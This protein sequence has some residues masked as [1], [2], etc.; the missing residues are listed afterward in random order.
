MSTDHIFPEPGDIDLKEVRYG[1]TLWVKLNVGRCTDDEII[2]LPESYDWCLSIPLARKIP[3]TLNI[4][5]TIKGQLIK[6]NQ[7]RCPMAKGDMVRTWDGIHT[8]EVKYINHDLAMATIE[9]RDVV[10]TVKLSD[11]RWPNLRGGSHDRA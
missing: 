5:R 9:C 11:L 3:L 4:K 1:D 2:L 10:K 6:N 8:W 7:A